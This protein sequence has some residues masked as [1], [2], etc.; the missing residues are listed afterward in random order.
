MSGLLMPLESGVVPGR[1][2]D[3]VEAGLNVCTCRVECMLH[4]PVLESLVWSAVR[5]T[6]APG[7]LA[8][9]T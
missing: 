6:H 5:R 7:Q 2:H 9:S 4:A 1:C 8:M 3:D